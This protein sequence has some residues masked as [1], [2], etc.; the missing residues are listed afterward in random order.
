M[1]YQKETKV[2]LI[3]WRVKECEYVLYM[4]EKT[5]G[6]CQSKNVEIVDNCTTV[7]VMYVCSWESVMLCSLCAN[8]SPEIEALLTQTQRQ[9]WEYELEKKN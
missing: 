7:I 2:G 5:V 4:R 6:S 3:E 1:F 9:I 8:G